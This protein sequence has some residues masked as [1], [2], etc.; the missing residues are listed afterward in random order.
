M[1]ML[2]SVVQ[3]LESTGVVLALANMP[4]NIAARRAVAG[5]PNAKLEATRKAMDKSRVMDVVRKSPM[6][7]KNLPG[8][9]AR[10]MAVTLEATAVSSHNTVLTLIALVVMV[11]RRDQ[12][13]AKVLADTV[14]Q[15]AWNTEVS[16][17][18]SLMALPAFQGASAKS[19]GATVAVVT[20]TM[21]MARGGKST[22]QA[23]TESRA[24]GDGT[25][26]P[27]LCCSFVRAHIVCLKR[28]MTLLL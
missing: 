18:T 6:A 3:V 13:T 4:R 20:M 22:V 23:D 21:N 12:A 7:V 26:H 14:V 9:N 2:T 27:A 24:M 8:M 25:R 28:M 16:D 17:L 5:R 15:K 10:N 11:V 19:L 1:M